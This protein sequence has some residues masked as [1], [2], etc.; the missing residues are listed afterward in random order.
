[1]KKTI[2]ILTGSELRHDF[3]RLSLCADGRLDVLSSYCEGLEKSVHNQITDKGPALPDEDAVFMKAH[4]DARQA[5]EEYY[6]RHFVEKQPTTGRVINLPKGGINHENIQSE[7]CGLNPDYIVCYGC[8]ILKGDLLDWFEGRILNLHLGLSPYY[9]GSGT[10]FFSL[11]N[12]E[13]ECVGGTFMILDAGIDTG[14]V[15]HQVRAR[16]VKG[17][18]PHDVGNRL[19]AD[20]A[21]IYPEVIAHFDDIRPVSIAMDEGKLYMRNDFTPEAT[22]QLYDAFKCGLVE[23]YIDDLDRRQATKPIIQA[24]VLVP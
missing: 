15:L 13:P 7:I 8:S 5:S 12:D 19:I 17:D 6:F 1:M 9:R 14:A 22:R 21:A 10:N 4:A 11:V 24:K 20:C 23:R 18:T 16:V 3:M 2:V